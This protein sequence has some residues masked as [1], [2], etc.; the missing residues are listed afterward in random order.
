MKTIAEATVTELKA[1]AFDIN[2]QILQLQGNYRAVMEEIQKRVEA[3]QS[4]PKEQVPAP[5]RKKAS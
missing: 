5:G 3:E 2:Q 4:K 1:F